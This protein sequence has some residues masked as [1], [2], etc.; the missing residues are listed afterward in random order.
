MYSRTPVTRILKGNE[1][2]FELARVRV[3]GVDL[4][5]LVAMHACYNYIFNQ[6]KGNLVRVIRVRSQVNR[7]KMIGKLKWGEIQGKLG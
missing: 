4:K 6:G 2:Q 5:N 7:V 1:K 3:I